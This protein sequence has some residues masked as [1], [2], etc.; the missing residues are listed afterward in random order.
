MSHVNVDFG[1]FIAFI[2]RW[3]LKYWVTDYKPYLSYQFTLL[4]DIQKYYIL[5]FI[6]TST[7]NNIIIFLMILIYIYIYTYILSS[8]LQVLKKAF[9]TIYSFLSWYLSWWSN[10]TCFLKAETLT[11]L[12]AF[13]LIFWKP[14]IHKGIDNQLFYSF[15]WIHIFLGNISMKYARS[16]TMVIV[17][18][19]ITWLKYSSLDCINN[20]LWL[21]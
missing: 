1:L 8:Y 12:T 6:G 14:N 19:S 20:Y 15:G 7:V 11:F 21:R 4:V 16:G 17:N 2:H 9:L 13:Y 3:H 5:F 18:R 10:C